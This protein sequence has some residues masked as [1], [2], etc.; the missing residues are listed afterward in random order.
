MR[1][2]VHIAA[3]SIVINAAGT[4]MLLLIVNALAIKFKDRSRIAASYL[5]LIS[6]VI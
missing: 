5:N 4:I 6:P 3:I 1:P 2:H